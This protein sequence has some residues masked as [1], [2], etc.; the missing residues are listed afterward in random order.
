MQMITNVRRVV[1]VACLTIALVASGAWVATGAAA[2]TVTW[3][4]TTVT[5][6][7]N[8]TT[9]TLRLGQRLVVS[10]ASNFDPPTVT[11]PALAPLSV[12]GGFPTGQPVSATYRAVA[13]GT[14]DVRSQTDAAC[15]HT[16]PYC[17][18]P[19]MLWVVHVRII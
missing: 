10:L 11:G 19:V 12:T 6:A 18:M 7:D 15:F 1:A 5:V 3:G 14:V 13:R 8:Q 16:P 2:A 17:A 9:V 4:T